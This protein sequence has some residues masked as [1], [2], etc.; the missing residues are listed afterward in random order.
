MVRQGHVVHLL[1]EK[2]LE[3]A[4]RYSLL[5]GNAYDGAD[6][7]AGTGATLVEHLVAETQETNSV[8]DEPEDVIEPGAIVEETHGN[9][10]DA[11]FPDEPHSGVLPLAL[12]DGPV[13]TGLEVCYGSG[14]EDA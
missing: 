11:G 3:F 1:P 9:H 6:T 13:F 5:F 4:V 8:V 2:I 14:G 7:H 10:R 12:V